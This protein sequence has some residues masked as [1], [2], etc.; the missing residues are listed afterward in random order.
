MLIHHLSWGAPEHCMAGH[1]L[2]EHHA[3]RVQVRA[4]VH[5]HSGEPAKAPGIEIAASLGASGAG[6]AR[7]RSMI[8]AVTVLPSSTLTM[9]LLGLMSRWTSFCLW[10]AAKPAATCVVISSASFASS[11]LKRLMRLSNVSP[12]TNSIA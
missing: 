12:S 8:L 11:R 1:H 10:T 4:D 6:L 2:P 7:P 9:M 5:A 3:Q